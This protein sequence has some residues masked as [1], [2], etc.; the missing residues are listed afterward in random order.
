MGKGPVVG[1]GVGVV[2]GGLG[3]RVGAGAGVGTGGEA[4]DA[5]GA[6]PVTTEP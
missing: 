5:G 3:V 1:V 4:W 6:S 2:V